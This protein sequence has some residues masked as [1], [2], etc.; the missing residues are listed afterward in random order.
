[1]ETDESAIAAII[2]R[3][4]APAGLEAEPPAPVATAAP[5][6]VSPPEPVPPP[7]PPLPPPPAPTL[8]PLPAPVPMPVPTPAPAAAADPAA[9]K[10][11]T[12]RLSAS[13]LAEIEK[14]AK[15]RPD[16][17]SVNT[18]LIG[19]ALQRLDRRNP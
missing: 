8:A 7:P 10:K 3:G 2:N 18:W 1:V 19:A 6:V 12:L 13:L 16:R 4:G 11:F 15:G 14:D 5:L 9:E 17:I